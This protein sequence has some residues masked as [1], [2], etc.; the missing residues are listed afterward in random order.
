MTW[1]AGGTETSWQVQYGV[2]GFLLG[3]GT[4][5]QTT[6]NAM[7][8]NGLSVT[9]NYD[10]YVR[11]NCSTTEN[12]S[13]IG[14]VTLQG[15][16]TIVYGNMSANVNSQ[17]HNDM[18]PYLYTYYGIKA[19]LENPNYLPADGK[20]LVVQGN[21]D[22]LT[23]NSS[24]FTEIYINLSQAFWQPGTYVLNPATS[25]PSTRVEATM[26]I[27]TSATDLTEEVP[28]Q[29]TITIVEFDTVNKRIRGTF[30]FPYM[31]VSTTSSTGPFQVTNGTFDFSIKD[32]VFQ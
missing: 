9:D 28:M 25:T 26:R 8:L 29:G 22:P 30:S 10:F 24:S 19:K 4:I 5:V 1:A 21:T 7:V 3:S 23:P 13:W 11:S 31:E 20:V 15:L 27:V 14:P 32:D 12:S 18:K 16:F 6:T 17:Q 2:S